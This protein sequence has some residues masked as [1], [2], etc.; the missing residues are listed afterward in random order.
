[1]FPLQMVNGLPASKLRTYASSIMNDDDDSDDKGDDDD[2]DSS[3]IKISL[4]I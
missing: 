2:K 4:R 3:T 1:M